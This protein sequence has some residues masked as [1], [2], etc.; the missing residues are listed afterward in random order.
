MKKSEKNAELGVGGSS[1]ISDFFFFF[2]YYYYFVVVVHVSKKKWLEGWV[3]V[4]WQIRV[5]LGFSIFFNMTRPL[6]AY[7][8][9][10]VVVRNKESKSKQKTVTRN[11]GTLGF[12]VPNTQV[13]DAG[14]DFL[15]FLT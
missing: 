6:R 1:S 13:Y 5:F 3:G 9:L 15:F 14:P 12:Q 7:V 2:N 11:T 8:L 4:V 10:Q